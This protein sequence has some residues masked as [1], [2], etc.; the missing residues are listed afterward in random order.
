MD[1]RERVIKIIEKEKDLSKNADHIEKLEVLL[2]EIKVV[3]F[4]SEK[5]S[6]EFVKRAKTVC[7]DTIPR[8][9]LYEV[10]LLIKEAF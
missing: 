7:S 1:I 2:F 9:E 10:E 6:L 4:D 5:R 8:E 3:D